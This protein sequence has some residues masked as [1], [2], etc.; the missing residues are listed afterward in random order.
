MYRCVLN[1]VIIMISISMCSNMV[2]AKTTSQSVSE[3]NLVN[4]ME[5]VSI[6]IVKTGK[7]D[8]DKKINDDIMQKVRLALKDDINN[9]NLSRKNSYGFSYDIISESNDYISIKMT[10]SVMNYGMFHPQN[11]YFYGVVYSK[12]TGNIVPL[13]EFVEISLSDI[14]REISRGN[15]YTL[16]GTKKVPNE[17][18]IVLSQIPVDYVIRSDGSIALVFDHYI[19]A[20]YSVG[21]TSVNITSYKKKKQDLGMTILS[22]ILK[23]I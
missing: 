9:K 2:F 1:M 15:I 16:D 11:R 22:T 10:G 13:R 14:N 12:K 5:R 17:S 23:N 3:Y 21:P 8:V 6:P 4:G 18:K 19:L 20:S 7:S